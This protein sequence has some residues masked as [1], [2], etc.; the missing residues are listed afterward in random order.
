M[1]MSAEKGLKLALRAAQRGLGGDALTADHGLPQSTPGA[2]SEA[3][4]AQI[5]QG[6]LAVAAMRAR[7][8]YLLT[9]ALK[10][11]HLSV[12]GAGQDSLEADQRAATIVRA[13]SAEARAQCLLAVHAAESALAERGSS[14]AEEAS[15]TARREAEQPLLSPPSC[16][17]DERARAEQGALLACG[18]LGGAS[19]LELGL[20][21]PHTPPHEREAAALAFGRAL[22]ATARA[23]A[24]ATAADAGAE[25]AEGFEGGGGF[26]PAEPIARLCAQH[27][28]PPWLVELW[29][30]S[31]PFAGPAHTGTHDA[32]AHAASAS[33]AGQRPAGALHAVRL[34]AAASGS[35]GP[36]TLRANTLLCSRAEL[37]QRLEAEGVRAQPTALSPWGVLLP[38]G[39]PRSARGGGVQ[40]LRAWA[41]GLFETQDEGSQLIALATAARPGDRVLDLCAGNGGKALALAAM[42]GGRGHLVAHDVDGRRLAQIG[43]RARRAGLPEGLLRTAHGG[44]ELAAVAAALGPG[45]ADSPSASA[46]KGGAAEGG[47]GGMGEEGGRALSAAFDVVLVDAPCSS[48]GVLRR[49]PSLRWEL[50]P[51]ECTVRLPA[52]QRS[53]LEQ[54]ARMLAPGGTLVYATCALNGAENEEVALWLLRAEQ[55][56]L[57]AA[58][59]LAL[60]PFPFGVDE[61]LPAAELDDAAGC[62]HMRWLLPSVHGT[63]GFFIARW[64]QSEASGALQ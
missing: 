20:C 50:S 64:R 3:E 9:A 14:A 1:G 5:A 8:E 19:L 53:L 17:P 38:D 61:H 55:R 22:A 44:A 56:A 37:L 48:S 54:G 10:E 16:A 40:N 60:E 6:V 13:L 41:D 59:G 18:W 31:Q 52:L 2:L 34:L 45:R 47:G 33:A 25:E 4:R 12:S 28:L 62:A 46:P 63:D 30:R 26:W 23:A 15:G 32:G 39:R 35:R 43:G 49:H 57:H 7:H 29:L 36:L 27:S 42:L 21:A 11:H 24:A 58:L 51:E